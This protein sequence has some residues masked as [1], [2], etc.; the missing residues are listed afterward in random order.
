MLGCI[1]STH[2][3]ILMRLLGAGVGIVNDMSNGF[4]ESVSWEEKRFQPDKHY[5]VQ[6][7]LGWRA[8][9]EWLG[10]GTRCDGGRVNGFWAAADSPVGDG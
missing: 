10:A 7:R 2:V 9:G 3:D 6:W 4:C 1:L 8:L 5:A